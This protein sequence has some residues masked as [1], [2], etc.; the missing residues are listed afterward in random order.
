MLCISLLT[1]AHCYGNLFEPAPI[2]IKEFVY[3]SAFSL[4]SSTTRFSL[5]LLFFG[6]FFSTGASAQ[7]P[8]GIGTTDLTFWLNANAGVT[9]SSGAVSQWDDQSPG[10][11]HVAQSNGSAQPFYGSV[12]LNYYPVVTFDA[13]DDVLHLDAVAV[14]AL[15]DVTSGSNA[16]TTGSL[17]VVVF[18]TAVTDVPVLSQFPEPACGE[19]AVQ[20]VINEGSLSAGGRSA[21]ATPNH[22]IMGGVPFISS[23]LED[24]TADNA[25]HYLNGGDEISNS[26]LS[27]NVCAANHSIRV[28]SLM[29]GSIAE[30][31][32]FDIRL[33]DTER[34]KIESYLAIKYGITMNATGG[35]TFGDYIATNGVTIWDAD[36][37]AAY[38]NN[39]IGIARD[40]DTGLLQKQSQQLDDSTRVYLSTLAAT[41]ADNSGSF[42]S[43]LQAV[44]IGNNAAAMKSLGSEEFPTSDGIYSRV[45]R[46]WKITNTAFDGTFS[47]DIT[48]STS[49]L[50]ADDLRILIDSDGDF[51]DATLYN[52]FISINGSTVTISGIT[53]AMIPANSTRYLTIASLSPSS[54]LPVDLVFFEAVCQDQDVLLSWKTEAE[55]NNAYFIPERSN[56]NGQWKEIAKV[57]GQGTSL[58]PTTYVLTDENPGYGVLYYRLSQVDLDG[59]RFYFDTVSVVNA[60][61]DGPIAA[62]NPF[63]E[64]FYITGEGI[65]TYF[66]YNSS[67]LLLLECKTGDQPTSAGEKPICIDSGNLIAGIYLLQVVDKNGGTHFF[68]LLKQH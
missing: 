18:P 33:T 1:N 4:K 58:I 43:N 46:E 55:K 32:A 29:N 27:T 56:G 16:N 8:G 6:L 53:T 14:N 39:V 64:H 13:T 68:R 61:K 11:M 5:C 21:L 50:D 42:G 26:N 2:P 41:N 31:I 54:P 34:R 51:S 67:G 38:H 59:N 30:I 65:D 52:P 25:R 20:C 24:P 40:D 3:N 7:T 44:I 62:P 66:L 45:E 48:L 22:A 9:H 47:M 35:G 12:T 49:V 60:V 19:P 17:F 28:G 36:A 37:A 63:N 15:F 57:P 23:A 10:A